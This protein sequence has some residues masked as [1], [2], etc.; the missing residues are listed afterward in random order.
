M[1]K[2]KLPGV[3]M[4]TFLGIVL[5]VFGVICL[6]SPAIAGGA[7]TY[8][9]GAL[10]AAA[11]LIQ[12]I[13][14]LREPA[15]ASKLL[16]I[17]L[18]CIMIVAGVSVLA[19]PWIGMTVLTIVLAV[20]FVLEGCWKIFASFAFR[21][22]VGWLG[23]LLS[24]I[25]AIVIGGLIWAEWPASALWA[26]GVLVGVDLMMT[27]VAMVALATTVRQ[28]HTQVN[29]VVNDRARAADS[30]PVVEEP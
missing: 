9:V 10:L 3:A 26:I 5:I 19:H 16:P 21:P 15:W 24:G 6:V 22:A 2:K 30:P 27:G 12:V 29:K 4:L 7:I 1:N 28:V 8:V 20:S 18:G 11:G 17:I 23:L 13:Q 14:G 25:I